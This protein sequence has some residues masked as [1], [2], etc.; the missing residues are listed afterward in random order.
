MIHTTLEGTKQTKMEYKNRL[1]NIIEY[2]EGNQIP[3]FQPD[4]KDTIVKKY[5]LADGNWN[6]IAAP[7]SGSA[8]TTYGTSTKVQKST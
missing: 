5:V 1:R 7:E 4:S 6:P 2:S 3:G 8:Y